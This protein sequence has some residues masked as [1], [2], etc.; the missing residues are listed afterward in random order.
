MRKLGKFSRQIELNLAVRAGL[1][2]S[3]FQI[4]SVIEAL[5]AHN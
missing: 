1:L 3:P 5:A 2:K 4:I